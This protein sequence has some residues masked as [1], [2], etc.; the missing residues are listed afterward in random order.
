MD[1]PVIYEAF[2]EATKTITCAISSGVASRLT[3]T[4]ETS[5]LR[6]KVD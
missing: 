4:V 3:G 1:A 5:R 6:K 2:A